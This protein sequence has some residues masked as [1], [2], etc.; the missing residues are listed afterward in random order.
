MSGAEVRGTG[1][2]LSNMQARADALGGVLSLEHGLA[3]RGV[4][5]RVLVP[6]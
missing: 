6:L 1:Q 4:A 3:G 5:L 2:G